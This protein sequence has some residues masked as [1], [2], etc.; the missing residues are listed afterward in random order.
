MK[1]FPILA[2]ALLVAAAPARAGILEEMAE[3]ER[4][5]IPAL[6]LTNQPKAPVV[7]V[8]ASLKRL[9]GAMPRFERAF[10]SQGAELERAIRESQRAALEAEHLLAQNKRAAAHDALERIRPA[11]MRARGALN[12]ELYVDRLTEFH[13]VMEELVK[14]ADGGAT[15]VQLRGTFAQASGLWRNAERLR[16]EPGLFGFDAGGYEKLRAMTLA[17]REALSALEAALESGERARIVE[18]AQKV[19]STFSRIYVSFGDFSGL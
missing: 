14:L 5:Y 1:I 19:K 16:F 8:E 12:I 6:A 4:V 10:V 18:L 9:V 2:A 17:Q 13:D 7:R 15:P 11:M 3:F